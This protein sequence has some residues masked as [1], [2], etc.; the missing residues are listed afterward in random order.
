M[1]PEGMFQVAGNAQQMPLVGS[2]VETS[3]Q[4]SLCSAHRSPALQPGML[5]WTANDS[6]PPPFPVKLLTSSVAFQTSFLQP[7]FAQFAPLKIIP[8]I[9]PTPQAP[10]PIPHC[11]IATAHRRHGTLT[12]W[13]T[14]LLSW[15]TAET[16]QM[17]SS[18][19]EVDSSLGVAPPT[20]SPSKVA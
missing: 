20:F 19:V 4:Q 8:K 14:S 3:D 18:L 5:T 11:H 6:M 1:R 9:P 7:L 2:K 13:S 12:S 10:T 16:S 17:R 15:T